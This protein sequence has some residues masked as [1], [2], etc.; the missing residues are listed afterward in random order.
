MLNPY[1]IALASIPQKESRN[2]PCGRQW[3]RYYRREMWALGLLRLP[4]KITTKILLKTKLRWN[5]KKKSSKATNNSSPKCYWNSR[6]RCQKCVLGYCVYVMVVVVVCKVVAYLADDLDR[7][8]TRTCCE[9]VCCDQRRRLSVSANALSFW[10]RGSR[11]NAKNAS[12]ITTTHN[13]TRNWTH[14]GSL[15]YI[16]LVVCMPSLPQQQQRP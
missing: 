5:V 1:F 8:A 11:S 10:S 9:C 12:H 3:Y 4:P 2:A 14:T 6:G 7:I 16:G 15:I 13:A